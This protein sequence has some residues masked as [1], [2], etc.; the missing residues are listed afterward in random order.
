LRPFSA[1][2]KVA[3]KPAPPAPTTLTSYKCCWTL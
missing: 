2:P 3:R 1:R